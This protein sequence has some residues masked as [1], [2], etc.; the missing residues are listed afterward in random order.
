[1]KADPRQIQLSESAGLNL[2]V[3]PYSLRCSRPQRYSR[4]YRSLKWSE[5]LNGSAN[6]D[7]AFRTSRCGRHDENGGAIIP[8]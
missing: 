8:H 2:P 4:A 1:M 7:A 5:V 6:R 3:G